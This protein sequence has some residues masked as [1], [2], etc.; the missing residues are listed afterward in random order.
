MSIDEER[1][2]DLKTP[3]TPDELA[4]LRHE[5][6]ERERQE[7]RKVSEFTCDGC[8]LAPVCFFAFDGYNTDGDCIASK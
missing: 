4:E 1:F 8:T 2:A 3:R 5:S 6:L 7:G